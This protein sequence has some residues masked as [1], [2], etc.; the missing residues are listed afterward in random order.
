MR[1]GDYGVPDAIV[2]RLARRLDSTWMFGGGQA[3]SAINGKRPRGL[4]M[5]RVYSQPEVGEPQ[6][7]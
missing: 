7:E 3:I 2:R 1:Q 5:A 6:R 4:M